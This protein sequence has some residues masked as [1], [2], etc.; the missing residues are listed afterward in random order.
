MSY[1]FLEADILNHYKNF[2]AT[3]CVV[4]T[5]GN[6]GSV[7]KY[8]AEFQKANEQ[9]PDPIPYKDFAVKLFHDFDAYL[10]VNA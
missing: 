9:I 5:K 10:M 8:S 1:S 6:E 2:K 4:G 3:V 7:V